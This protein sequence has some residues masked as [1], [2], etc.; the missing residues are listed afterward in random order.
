MGV[1]AGKILY[2]TK[3]SGGKMEDKIYKVYMYTNKINQKKYIGLTK[4]TLKK[5]SREK[6]NKI[7]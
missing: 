6:W 4:M 3:K 1:H 7:L 5:K 2:I